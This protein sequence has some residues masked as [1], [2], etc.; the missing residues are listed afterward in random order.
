MERPERFGEVMEAW[1]RR[2]ISAREAGRRLGVS[3]KTFQVWAG[4]ALNYGS[5][6]HKIQFAEKN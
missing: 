2:E 6:R 4:T 1:E 5:E 3:Y